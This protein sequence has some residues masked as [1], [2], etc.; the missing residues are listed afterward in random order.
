MKYERK[1]VD[2]LLKWN[3]K[4]NRDGENGKFVEKKLIIFRLVG[5]SKVLYSFSDL[6][7]LSHSRVQKVSIERKDKVSPEFYTNTH[8]KGLFKRK[9]GLP[10][11]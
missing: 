1:L 5:Q 8:L 11:M 7:L 4:N 3:K 2:L 10:K 6:K 9:I